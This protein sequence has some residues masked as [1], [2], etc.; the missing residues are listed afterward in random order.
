MCACVYVCVAYL[1]CVRVCLCIDHNHLLDRGKQDV[2]LAV[3][4][5]TPEVIA[6][7]CT[8][9]LS[10]FSLDG[11]RLPAVAVPRRRW[12]QFG[13][14]TNTSPIED[15]QDGDGDEDDDEDEGMMTSQVPAEPHQRDIR[16]LAA[17][18]TG[19]MVATG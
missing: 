19:D 17:S 2:L 12:R 14:N 15:R 18:P 4:P 1:L 3:V 7:T 8:T 11:T 6:I 16:C 5:S 13:E 10:L 9:E